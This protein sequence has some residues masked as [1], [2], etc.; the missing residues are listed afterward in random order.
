MD[1]FPAGEKK[2][3]TVHR[4]LGVLA[5]TR[6]LSSMISLKLENSASDNSMSKMGPVRLCVVLP[7]KDNKL[8]S[9]HPPG[10][11]VL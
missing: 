6:F 9:Y 11:V 10:P 4:T 5:Q 7:L 2:C 1:P 8:Q 3:L